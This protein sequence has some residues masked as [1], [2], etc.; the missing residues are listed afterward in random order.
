MTATSTWLI[1]GGAGYFRSHIADEFLTSGK[2]VV[3]YDSLQSG[4]LSRVEFLRRKHNKEIALVVAD[5]RDDTS[6]HETF[7]SYNPKGVVHAAA[8]KSVAESVQQP[9]EYMEINYESTKRLLA[10]TAKHMAK[11]FIFASTAAIYGS[12]ENSGP[13]REDNVKK[14][15]SPYGSSKLLAENELNKYFKNS[16]FKGTSLRFFNVVGSGSPEL[17]DNSVENLIPIVMNS[18]KFEQKPIIFGT[19]YKTP[20]GTCI[21]DYVDV[22]DVAR[23]SLS[24][25][26]SSG[27]LPLAMNVG[28]GKG[29]SVR[30][31]IELVAK[32]S[33]Q[34]DVEVIEVDRR[35]GDPAIL[36][37]E[38]SL[39]KDRLRFTSK[40]SLEE[41]IQSLYSGSS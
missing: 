11:D 19:D 17:M 41:S 20:D 37:A 12:P 4:L 3:L 26:D 21:R 36:F 40:F 28:T 35:Q 10:I 22:R 8:L 33:R 9:G 7:T 30:E 16:T 38:V 18:L 5:L 24:V 1:T 34:K 29:V 15:I 25:A 13:I 27:E 6:L 32:I 14:P 39:I 23:A 31:V 2:D